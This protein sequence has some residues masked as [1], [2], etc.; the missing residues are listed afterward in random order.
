MNKAFREVTN[1]YRRAQ[2]EE[3]THGQRV[4]RLYRNALRSLT[5]WR[6]KRHLWNTYAIQIRS[7]FDSNASLAPDSGYVLR[8]RAEH[9][10]H[11]ACCT[12]LWLISARTLTVLRNDYFERARRSFSSSLILILTLVRDLR[13]GHGRCFAAGARWRGPGTDIS[14][15]HNAMLCPC[16]CLLYA[17]GEPQC[18][19]CLV[20]P[21]SCA[22]QHLPWRRCSL[23]ASH[24][25]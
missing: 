10:A 19:T 18:R 5:D 16:A 23:M 4:T 6:P 12:C 8:T 1:F 21:S 24:L 25:R 15:M 14:H 17:G 20:A 3:L 7:E 11:Y 22:T 9:A 2:F 13:A